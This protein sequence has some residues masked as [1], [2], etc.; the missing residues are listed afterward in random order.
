M[1]SENLIDDSEFYEDDFSMRT[2]SYDE[3]SEFGRGEDNKLQE[4]QYLVCVDPESLITYLLSLKSHNKVNNEIIIESETIDEG[5]G[6]DSGQLQR[7]KE[8]ILEGKNVI[9]QLMDLETFKWE[10]GHGTEADKYRS[11]KFQ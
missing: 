4:Q 2:N 3:E 8:R 1:D 5:D 7:Y 6:R 11:R 9:T 10:Y